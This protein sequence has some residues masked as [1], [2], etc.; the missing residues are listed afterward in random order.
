MTEALDLVS[1][2]LTR[3]ILT[4]QQILEKTR[5]K[6]M[7]NISSSIRTGKELS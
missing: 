3:Y 1:P 2:P 5:E 7:D 4:M 6:G